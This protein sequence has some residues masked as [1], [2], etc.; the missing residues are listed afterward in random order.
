MLLHTSIYLFLVG[1]TFLPLY[2]DDW[3]TFGVAIVIFVLALVAYGIVV[4]AWFFHPRSFY[5]FPLLLIYCRD[6]ISYRPYYFPFLRWPTLLWAARKIGD[7]ASTRS[8][9]LDADAMSWL[10]DSLTDEEDFERFVAGIPG[11]Y[12]STQVKD[13]AKVLQQP[14]TDRSPKVILSFIDRSLSSDLPEETR[15]RRIEASLKAMRAHPYLLQRSF[16][17]ALQA[18]FTESAIFKTVDFV[19]LTDQHAN[20]DDANI[21]SLARCIITIAI[22]RLED[23]H[24]DEHWARIIQRRLDWPENVFHQHREQRDSIKLRNLIQLARELNTLRLDSDTFTPE[25]LGHL[26]REVCKLN[27]RNVAPKLQNEFCDLWN[28]LV[29][30]AQIPDQDS[31]LVSHIMLIL[32]LIRT[33]HVSLHHQTESQPPSSSAKINDLDPDIQY[34]SSYSPCTASHDLVRVDTSAKSDYKCLYRP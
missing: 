26:L 34:P 19:H 4:S 14:N 27:V 17:H 25:V 12:K 28:E 8:S 18:C 31:A 33:V 20:D 22:N 9:T 2:F 23:Y 15:Q 6:L 10:L 7:D 29:I 16:H 11:F 13:P 30:V 24:V 32:S 5:F 3:P 21:R 1:L